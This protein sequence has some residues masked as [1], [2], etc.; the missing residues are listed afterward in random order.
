MSG[1]IERAV[2]IESDRP[3]HLCR[4]GRVSAKGDLLTNEEVASDPLIKDDWASLPEDSSPCSAGSTKNL[5]RL[6]DD[7]EA[8]CRTHDE[9]EI[10]KARHQH[11]DAR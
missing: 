3:L 2:V 11:D 10:T 9:V 8:D 5:Q 4:L 6:L 1:G 7:I